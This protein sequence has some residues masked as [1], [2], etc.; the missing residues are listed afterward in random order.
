MNRQIAHSLNLLIEDPRHEAED[1]APP[2]LTRSG[3]A[4]PS[5]DVAA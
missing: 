1:G 4:S 5:S 3:G 2:S